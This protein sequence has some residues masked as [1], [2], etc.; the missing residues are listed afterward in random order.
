MIG[1]AVP[2]IRLLGSHLSSVSVVIWKCLDCDAPFSAASPGALSAAYAAHVDY[3][4]TQLDRETDVHFE[5]QRMD[6]LL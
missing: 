4:N 5:V 6:A 2:H 3:V 1:R